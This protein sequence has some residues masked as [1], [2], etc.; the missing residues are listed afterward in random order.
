MSVPFSVYTAALPQL[1]AK[2]DALKIGSYTLKIEPISGTDVYYSDGAAQYYK[3]KISLYDPSKTYSDIQLFFT[4][5]GLVNKPRS[6]ADE[7]F[8]SWIIDTAKQHRGQ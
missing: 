1:Q 8:Q 3:G 7:V 2:Y 5:D 4:D 6:S